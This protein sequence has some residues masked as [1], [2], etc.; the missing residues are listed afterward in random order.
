MKPRLDHIGLHV[1]DYERS[2]AFYE[3]AL[4]P[5]GIK[6]MMEP[7]PDVGGFGGEFPSS[8]SA[9]AVSVHLPWPGPSRPE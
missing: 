7:V 3:R 9:S 4:A 5:L 2:R 6:L 1:S 8:G